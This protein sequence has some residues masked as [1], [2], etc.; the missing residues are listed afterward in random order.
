MTKIQRLA[1]LCLV[2]GCGGGGDDLGASDGS[3]G[4]SI[5]VAYTPSSIDVHAKQGML[6]FVE[7][8]AAF[9][10]LP[11]TVVYPVIVQS[12][13]DFQSGA[14]VMPDGDGSYSATLYAKD[15]LAL[16]AHQGTLT[17][18]LYKDAAKTQQYSLTG[19]TLP[20]SITVDP[21]VSVGVSVGGNPVTPQPYYGDYPIPANQTVTVTANMPV[22]WSYNGGLGTTVTVESQTDT[23][24][25][26]RVSGSS[27]QW[28]N[29][30][31]A[32]LDYGAN[33]T[34]ITLRIQ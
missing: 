18:R 17:L 25:Q 3:G 32:S 29:V 33:S 19:A 6:R 4:S 12:G 14:A 1:L 30:Q 23:T 16:G 7:V 11:T 13:Q 10:P 34:T 28:R 21:P 31:A 26:L 2:L 22:A 8:G 15:T 5:A 24:F 20:Y 9:S 27:G